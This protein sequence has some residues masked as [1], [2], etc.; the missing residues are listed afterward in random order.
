MSE[1][2]TTADI[3]RTLSVSERT[4]RRYVENLVSLQ[5]GTLLIDKEAFDLIINRYSDEKLRTTSGQPADIDGV[6]EFFTDEEYGEF[7]KRLTE[8][9]FLK[10]R[11][12]TLQEE[13]SY[14]K[15]QYDT[16]MGVHKEFLQMHKKSLENMT[17]RNWIEAKE[18]GLD[19]K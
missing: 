7:Q 16:L 10:K 17:Q 14:H 5:K 6:T 9:P 19:N 2:F 15:Q 3:A 18:K 12:D 13:I 8:Y 11:I 1:K 4:A